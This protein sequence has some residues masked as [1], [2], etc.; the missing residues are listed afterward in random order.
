MWTATA[1]VAVRYAQPEL[2]EELRQ[3]W[4]AEIE[5]EDLNLEDIFLE[6]HQVRT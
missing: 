5:V 6:L 2:I 3:K 4:Q 1:A